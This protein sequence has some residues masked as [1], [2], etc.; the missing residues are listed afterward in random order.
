MRV[1]AV[2]PCFNGEPFLA[3]ALES[4]RNQTHAVDELIVV[5]DGST[6]RSA[7]IAESF[8]A[9]VI[10]QENRGDGAARN[11]GTAV[12]TGD[13]IAWLDA[14]D[15][16]LPHHV[17]VLTGLL[18]RHREAVAAFGAVQRFGSRAEL[19]RGYVPPGGPRAVL[20]EAFR[21]WLHTT[22]GAVLRR[23]A[24]LDIG[25]LDETERY[26][27]D[28]DL[29][30]RLAQRHVFVATHEVT[31][32][33][34]WHPAQQ[35]SSRPEQI[36]ATYRFRRRFIDAMWADGDHDL[37]AALEAELATV[38][39][40]AV[41]QAVR[42]RD[43]AVLAALRESGKLVPGLTGPDRL[44]HRLAIRAPELALHLRRLTR[45]APTAGLL[46]RSNR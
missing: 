24:L 45:T 30:L 2:V 46:S 42:E 12:A 38:W 10:R 8:G 6:D 13:V 7:E 21:D 18:H 39:T 44:A 26:A 36:A 16:W 11:R 31:A 40:R 41:R 34:R 29:W 9:F 20:F 23:S 17:A 22:I 1:S 43:R 15:R 33:W 37:A 3:D 25:G 4:V 19:I 14:D 32:E 27:V 28:F 35:S 5:D